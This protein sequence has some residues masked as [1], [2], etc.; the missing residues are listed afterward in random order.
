MRLTVSF[1]LNIKASKFKKEDWLQICDYFVFLYPRP[2]K[3]QTIKISI[4]KFL[5][6]VK[7]TVKNGALLNCWM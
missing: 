6:H 2:H 7:S 4:K 3:L 1:M 5:V